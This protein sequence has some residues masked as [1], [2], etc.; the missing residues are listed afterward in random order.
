VNQDRVVL[1]VVRKRAQDLDL[2]G[3][4]R[5]S[6]VEMEIDIVYPFLL[7]E[8]AFFPVPS[9]MRFPSAKIDDEAHPEMVT[10]LF[11]FTSWG[12]SAAIEHAL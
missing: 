3:C 2:G 5:A 7:C 12:L 1:L 8:L 9:S 11:Y 6:A 10:T 4:R